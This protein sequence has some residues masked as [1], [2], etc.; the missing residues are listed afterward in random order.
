MRMDMIGDI[1]VMLSMAME[2]E[3]IKRTRGTTLN[4]GTISLTIFTRNVEAVKR[5]PTE[6]VGKPAIIENMETT[7]QT[8]QTFL[9][10]RQANI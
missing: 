10:G 3:D 8:R 9:N 6:V 4:D 2:G 5:P 7:V 1:K